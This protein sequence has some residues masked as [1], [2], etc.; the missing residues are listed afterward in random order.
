LAMF[1]ISDCY[2]PIVRGKVAQPPRATR[3]AMPQ[4]GIIPLSNADVYKLDP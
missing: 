4:T 2:V 1:T 3:N